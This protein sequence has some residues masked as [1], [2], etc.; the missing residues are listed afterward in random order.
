M[1]Q[2]PLLPSSERLSKVTAVVSI[3]SRGQEHKSHC[4]ATT[5]KVHVEEGISVRATFSTREPGL[6]QPQ[7]CLDEHLLKLDSETCRVAC[8][9]YGLCASH[10]SRDPG[11]KCKHA[12]TYRTRF[13]LDCRTAT[14]KNI[15]KR[16]NPYVAWHC[17]HLTAVKEASFFQVDSL[18]RLLDVALPAAVAYTWVD[19]DPPAPPG[20]PR[21][22]KQGPTARQEGAAQHRSSCTLQISFR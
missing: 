13:P 8:E 16:I 2:K 14:L 20:S 5:A 11:G 21:H 4:L 6:R 12:R 1:Q 22:G 17:L 10:C 3:S 9:G 15:N 19:Q 7:E 18:G